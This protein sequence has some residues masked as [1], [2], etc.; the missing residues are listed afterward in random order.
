MQGND[1]TLHVNVKDRAKLWIAHMSKIMNEEDEWDQIVDADTVEGPIESDERR[2]KEG[3][4]TL[5]DST[6]DAYGEMILSRV[7]IQI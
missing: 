1:G 3:I 5:E 7:D 6:F 2:D 4:Q